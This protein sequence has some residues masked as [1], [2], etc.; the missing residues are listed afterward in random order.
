MNYR[1]ATSAFLCVPLLAGAQLLSWTDPVDV[2][3]ANAGPLRPRIVLNGSGVPVVLWADLMDHCYAAVGMGMA[4]MP[5]V[6]LSPMDMG[7]ATSDW[8]GPSLAA[9]GD[10]LWAVF[11][12]LPEDARPSYLIGSIDGGQTWGDTLRIDPADGLLSRFPAV[13]V[14]AGGEPVVQ[15]MQFDA[16]F[17]Q[18]RHV[19]RHMANGMFMGLAQVSSPFAP[20]NVCDC[21]PGQVVA[22]GNRVAALYRNAG[23][24]I[25][26]IWGAT[27][28]DGGMSFPT[29]E[30]LDA[31]NWLLAACPSSGPA[32]YFAGDSLRYVWMSGEE[33]GT[34]V[35][36]GSADAA[37]LMVGSQQNVHPG[38]AMS[39]QQ[40]Y[41]RIA[42]SGDTLGV[43][44]EQSSGGSREVLFSWSTSGV[45]GLSVPDTVNVDHDGSQETPD[46]AFADGAF[47]IVW[48]E[49]NTGQVRYRK[50][51]ILDNVS[52]P[53][54]AGQPAPRS[55][56][57]PVLD[58]LHVEGNGW[59]SANVL[60]T[61]GRSV[62]SKPVIAG[63]IDLS[64]LR[65]GSYS[66]LL[67]DS[68]DRPAILQ[69]EKR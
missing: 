3:P 5:P 62:A 24:N 33:N 67:K 37:T 58:L 39:V 50:A 10:T 51:T 11:K 29:G 18:A 47:H 1:Y 16:G 43:V 46:I 36:L 9:A 63:T 28:N 7:I 41:P 64:A 25:R 42:G 15:Y 45:T 19:V 32:G 13:A 31:T 53:G 34:K 8:Q 49:L 55:W 30:Q 6:M 26:T 48:S 27:S 54:P 35:Y 52:V 12:G 56:P 66:I 59:T 65:P 17:G 60:D 57:N 61:Q 20:G 69:L 23:G 40:N 44:W 22:S 68:S 2:A 21:C 14:T 38:Q 4:F